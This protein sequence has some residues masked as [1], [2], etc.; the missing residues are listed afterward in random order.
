MG[1]KTVVFIADTSF[2]D[3]QAQMYSAARQT[4]L[5]EGLRLIKITIETSVS[6]NRMAGQLEHTVEAV[7]RLNPDG[8]VVLSWSGD[9]VS[10][11]DHFMSMLRSVTKAPII[12]LGRILPDIPSVVMNGPLLMR[13][14]LDHLYSVH[15]SRRIVFIS[16]VTTDDR[17]D[18]YISFMKEKGIYDPSLIITAEELKGYTDWFFSRRVKKIADVILDERKISPDAVMSMYTFE[19]AFL[20]EELNS[21]GISIPDD[22]ILTSW[23]DGERGRF[24]LPS[25]TSV[26]YPFYEQGAEAVRLVAELLR[27]NSVPMLTYVNGRVVIR[28]SCGCFSEKMALLSFLPESS[29][30]DIPDDSEILSMLLRYDSEFTVIPIA[31][32]INAFYSDLTGQTDTR[33]MKIIEK[34][35]F[36]GKAK[37]GDLYGIQNTVLSF[38]RYV[39]ELFRNSSDLVVKSENIFHRV[40]FTVDE[41]VESVIGYEDLMNRGQGHMLREFGQN[42]MTRLSTDALKDVLERGFLKNNIRSCLIFLNSAMSSKSSTLFFSYTDEQRNSHDEEMLDCGT[43]EK[44][45]SCIFGDDRKTCIMFFLHVGD[46]LLG[47]AVFDSM[48]PDERIYN[49][50]SIEISTALYGIRTMEQ[51]HKA[52]GKL[53]SARKTAISNMKLIRQKS[54][55]LEISNSRLFELDKLKNEFIANI[56]HD[57]RSPLMVIMNNA[58]LG[59]NYDDL[60]KTDTTRRRYDVISSAS[61]KLRNSVDRLLDLAKM[62]A[63][64]VRLSLS[65]IGISDFLRNITEFYKSASFSTGLEIV[66]E[67]ISDPGIIISDADKLD[68][69]MNNLISNAVKFVDKDTGRIRITLKASDA[70]AEISVEDNGIGIPPDKLE[71]VFERFERLSNSGNKGIKGSGI[72]LAFVRQLSV[73]IDSKVWAESEGEGKGSRFVIDLKNFLNSENGRSDDLTMLTDRGKIRYNKIENNS[74]ADYGRDGGIQCEIGARNGY[75]ELDPRRAVILIADDSADIRQILKEYLF[76]EGYVNFISVSNGKDAVE[77]VYE[78]RPDLII[79]DFNMPEMRGDAFHDTISLN[80]DFRFIPVIFISAVKDRDRIIERKVKGAVSCLSKPVDQKELVAVVDVQIK[81]YFEMKSLFLRTSADDLTGLLNKNSILDFLR[82]RIL[83]R[84]YND[85]SVILMDI[86]HFK[87]INTEF[88]HLAGDIVLVE[89]GKVLR[90][91]IRSYDRAGRSGGE[92]FIII[93]P[94]CSADEAYIAAQKI[95]QNISGSGIYYGNSK[96]D[97]TATFGISSLRENSRYIEKTLGVEN[98]GGIFEVLN[99]HKADWPQIDNI[100]IKT[101]ELLVKMAEE[102]LCLGKSS[103]C[104]DCGNIS[105]GELFSSSCCACGS[106]NIRIGGNQIVVFDK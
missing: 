37:I 84:K 93:L 38:R 27:G 7:K 9:I 76:A 33:F 14:L 25:I 50:L 45:K 70:G 73:Y 32:I 49:A 89:I 35:V 55:A 65:K 2:D 106:S 94:D 43:P 102:A 39:I 95:S 97:F 48:S 83:L 60:S 56:T 41:M 68:E 19:A 30:N 3:F 42:I 96:M 18:E 100:K 40:L 58:D 31:D 62:D 15:S 92:E 104:E 8:I 59:R 80:P 22:F 13:G 79:T 85:L 69:I 74:G 61:E 81:K 53:E 12:S 66:Y 67:C 98:L 51:L 34:K 87:R 75:A 36:Y 64:G 21:R 16:P 26:Y 57:F 6:I 72:G 47:Y 86:D 11:T 82:S 77:A 10:N 5:N 17:I 29:S 99:P 23:E 78:Y 46:E 101:S 54:A 90:R 24:S 20:L 4:A 91:S 28:R 1:V 63:E 52:N 105:S 103:E 71:T 44:L 88:G